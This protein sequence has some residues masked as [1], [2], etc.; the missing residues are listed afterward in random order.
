MLV[1]VL[2]SLSDDQKS[3]IS[4]TGFGSIISFELK[5]YPVK[6][7]EFMLSSFEP[8]PSVLKIN[9]IFFEIAEEDVHEIMGLPREP[10]D[11]GFV[12][13]VLVKKGWGEIFGP[14]KQCYQVTAAKLCNFISSNKA[15]INQFKM[16]FMVLFSNVLIEGSSTPY[17]NTN[18][19]EFAGDFDSC[20]KYNWCRYLIQY[21]QEQFVIWNQNRERRFFKG[22][23]AFLMVRVIELLFF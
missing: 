22:S 7:S 2:S 5:E 4:S 6:L 19:V 10:E 16:N 18:M 13:N 11:V 21:L 9:E 3:W 12:N 20:K 17:V 23:L 15:V 1:G 14:A 8:N